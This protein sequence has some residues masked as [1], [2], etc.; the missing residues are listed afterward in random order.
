M[1]VIVAVK[2][3]DHILVACDSQI[4]YGGSKAK[5][6]S[7]YNKAWYVQDCPYGVMGSTGS[8]R[9]LQ[10]I[11]VTPNLIEELTQFRNEV[12][13]A[14]VVSE[15]YPR[16]CN[17]MEHY[18]LIAPDTIPVNLP[19]DFIFAYKDKAWGISFDGAV[20]ELVDYICIGSGAE[21][22]RGIM[23]TTKDLPALE[24]ITRAITA[25][26]DLTIYVDKDI[27]V[28][29]TAAEE[30]KETETKQPIEE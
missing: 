16:I 11:Q 5:L 8:L 24:R 22:A 1:S 27:R 25:C 18:K 14:Y 23:E 19:N 15:L 10:V 12:D 7:G 17:V 29:S 21:T 30:D 2:E 20:E 4:S 28:Y 3:K 9:A 26:A 13:F 6:S